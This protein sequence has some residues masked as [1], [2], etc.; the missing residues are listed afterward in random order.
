MSECILT[1]DVGV[2]ECPICLKFSKARAG[3]LGVFQSGCGHEWHEEM[4]MGSIVM[5]R[6]KH[7][8]LTRRQ[9]GELT[10]LQSS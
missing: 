10:G 7:L 9:M 8:K 1:Q 5:D 2:L 4:W 3:W 6:R